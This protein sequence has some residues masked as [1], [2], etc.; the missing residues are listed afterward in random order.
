MTRAAALPGPVLRPAPPWTTSEWIN[1]PA[2][3]LPDLRGRVVVLEAF[4]MLCPGCVAHALPQARRLQ[5]TFRP[6]DV[7][8]VAL[9]TVFEHHAAMTPVA[10]RAF[11]HEYRLTFPVGVD[12]H[13]DALLPTT[14]TAYRMRGTPT[15]VL[16]DRAGSIRAQHFGAVDDMLLAAQVAALSLE[17]GHAAA[18]DPVPA[19]GVCVAGEGCR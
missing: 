18:A 19:P 5:E 12:A 1:S 7:A 10:L 16:I 2:L 6:D 9:H 4:Q 14:F 17:R 15:T 3:S 13:D 11:V 8:V